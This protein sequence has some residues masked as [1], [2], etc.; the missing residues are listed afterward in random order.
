MDQPVT[1]KISPYYSC[2]YLEGG[3]SFSYSQINACAIL[4]HGRGEP[5]LQ[6]HN[7]QNFSIE[8]VEKQKYSI[9]QKN[10][11]EGYSACVGC[12]NLEKKAWP[13]KKYKFDWVGI[14]HFI[15]CNISCNYC[16]LQWADWSPKKQK[17]PAQLY[18]MMPIVERLINTRLL[19]PAG[20][21][22]WGGGGEPTIIPEFDEC[23]LALDNYGVIQWLHTNAVRMPRQLQ[24]EDYDCSSVKVLCSID[25]GNAETYKKIKGR[26]GF[27]KAWANLERYQKL[28]AE[29]TLKYI[30]LP[31][32]CDEEN[33]RGF[34][35]RAGSLGK[36]SIVSDIDIR[37]PEPSVAILQGLYS[38]HS[39]AASA[40]IFIRYG[41]TGGNSLMEAGVREQIKS[42][43][44]TL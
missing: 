26:D 36:L 13:R 43:T 9:V 42:S 14:T 12:P 8:T 25:A 21:I 31:E 38:L 28:G 2:R 18:S 40:G 23:F 33:T 30:V 24:A 19:D 27:D 20:I 4:H 41:S 6:D 39:K 3:I 5:Y 37:S 34:I 15:Y 35:E 7:G 17:K 44:F 29:I 10:Q 32:N 1:K 11:A 22:D 16:W